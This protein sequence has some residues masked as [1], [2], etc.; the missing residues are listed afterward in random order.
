[1][2]DPYGN[3]E[4]SGGYKLVTIGFAPQDYVA[5]FPYNPRGQNETHPVFL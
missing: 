4:P 1:M 2:N 3:I 5:I